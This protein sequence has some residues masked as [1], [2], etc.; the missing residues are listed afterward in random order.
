VTHVTRKKWRKKKMTQTINLIFTL[1]D[2]EINQELYVTPQTYQIL[3]KQA[4]EEI[5]RKYGV[6]ESEIR[7][8][9]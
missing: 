9:K 2:M 6:P 1:D 7:V 4:K 8:L 5:T 3:V